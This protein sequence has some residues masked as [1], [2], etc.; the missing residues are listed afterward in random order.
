[1][2]AT[3]IRGGEGSQAQDHKQAICAKIR[4][5]VS[6]TFAAGCSVFFLRVFY[7]RFAGGLYIHKKKMSLAVQE[8]PLVIHDVFHEHCYLTLCI[9]Y[10]GIINVHY[11]GKFA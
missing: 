10:G 6:S 4:Y 2:L 7:D 8:V 11:F 9:N 1:M 5:G 3:L